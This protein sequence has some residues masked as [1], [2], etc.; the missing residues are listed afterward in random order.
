MTGRGLAGTAGDA[1]RQSAAPAR[2]ARTSRD[3]VAGASAGLLEDYA[4]VAEGFLALS[5]VTGE[6]RWVE[7]AGRLLDTALDRFADGEGGFFDT[8]DDGEPLLYRPADPADN[9]TPSGAFA[10]AAALLSYSALT[11]SAAHREAALAALGPVAAIARRFPRA[12]GSGRAA[13]AARLAGPAEIAIIGPPGDRRTAELHAAALRA[14]PPGAVLAV[15]DGTA[16]TRIPL[17]AG[18]GLVNGAP[19][20]YVCRDFTCRAPVTDPAELLVALSGTI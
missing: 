5:G 2:V 15:G 7:L 9:A 10:A 4:C 12:A 16:D 8:A 13:A 17:L 3:G 18:R 1:A 20:A 6:G 11:G 19:A 14:A